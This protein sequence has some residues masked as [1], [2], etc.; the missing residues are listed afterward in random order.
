MFKE[1]ILLD[2][3]DSYHFSYYVIPFRWGVILTNLYFL[4]RTFT[5]IMGI[6]GQ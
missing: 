1:V 3:L 6:G 4:L 5:S 2:Y